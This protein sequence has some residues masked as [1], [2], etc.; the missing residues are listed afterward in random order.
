MSSSCRCLCTPRNGE[1][2]THVILLFSL[3]FVFD[4]WWMR[5]VC[6]SWNG[7]CHVIDYSEQMRKTV[8]SES[9]AN[10]NSCELFWFFLMQNLI[11]MISTDFLITV[12]LIVFQFNEL[13]SDVSYLS[14]FKENKHHYSSH[15]ILCYLI[16]FHSIFMLKKKCFKE[17]KEFRSGRCRETH[18]HWTSVLGNQGNSSQKG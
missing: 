4:F 12:Q 18:K 6:W 11:H 13:P 14:V 10:R 15:R 17:R 9:F 3:V 16:C 1:E 8:V 7:R 5:K 2:G